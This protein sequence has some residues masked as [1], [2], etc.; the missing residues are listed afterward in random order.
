MKNMKFAYAFIILSITIVVI[1]VFFNLIGKQMISSKFSQMASNSTYERAVNYYNL[2]L[3]LSPKD[4]TARNNLVNLYI[5][6]EDYQSAFYNIDQ[7]IEE[8]PDN[9]D[10]YF[11]KIKLTEKLY[12][13]EQAIQIVENIES[14]Y[15][16]NKF[17]T[18][19]LIEPNFNLT[20]GKY[21]QNIE[22]T[23]KTSEDANVYY[24]INAE[25]YKIY[26]SPI[27]LTD[28][29][30]DIFAVSI[31]EQGIVSEEIE[32][33]YHVENLIA[34]VFFSTTTTISSIKEQIGI[35]DT[36]DRDGLL[37]LTQIDLSSSELYDVDIQTLIN[38]TNLEKLILGDV[39]YV[40][41]LE[42]LKKLTNLSEITIKKGCTVNLLTQILQIETLKKIEITNSKI[43][44]LPENRT[45]LTTLILKNCLI[46]D[47]QN[48]NSY[49]TVEHLDLSVN[50]IM[51]I[52]Q[53][54][55]LKKLNYLNLSNNKI[56]DISSILQTVSLKKIDL[57]YN[58]IYSIKNMSNLAF[59]ENVNLSN[60]QIASVL[61]F[62]N[63]KYLSTLNCSYNNIITLEPL[64]SSTSLTEIYANNNFITDFS[65]IDKIENLEYINISNNVDQF[66]Q[67]DD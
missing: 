15:V 18:K 54:S 58:E 28:G 35:E 43:N 53:L 6:N 20:S 16:K 48:I 3:K 23:I 10:L 19:T 59:L 46:F 37:G 30:Y 14:G 38:C 39:T 17:S 27:A 33:F 11:Y 56:I 26:S 2:A 7:G 40:T 21:F 36:I 24:K 57:S 12:D 66:L 51:D 63:L 52:S 60:N 47:I 25:K 50:F 42:P 31:N 9:D 45:S 34:P 55:N 62:S 13:I 4:A 8:N 65:Y 49:K 5:D 32:M 67:T 64:I 29:F 41:S 44:I 1:S 61:E 22:V